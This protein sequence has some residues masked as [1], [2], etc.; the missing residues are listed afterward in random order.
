M[1]K[2]DV[3]IYSNSSHERKYETDSTSAMKAAAKFG[4]CE[5]GEV[6]SVVRKRTGQLLSR[7]VWNTELHDYVHVYIG[8]GVKYYDCD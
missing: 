4:R 7:A 8:K 6:V 5:G 2:Y 3:F 1:A